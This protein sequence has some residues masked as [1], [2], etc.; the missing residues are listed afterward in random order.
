M[1]EIVKLFAAERDGRAMRLVIGPKGYGKNKWVITKTDRSLE[2]FDK[3]GNLLAA[4]VN[5]T[6][7]AYAAR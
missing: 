4:K 6:L 3:A 5:V 7:K 2:R 1:N